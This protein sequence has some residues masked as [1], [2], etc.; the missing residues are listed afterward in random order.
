[1]HPQIIF[2]HIPKTAGTSFRKM[3]IEAN[4]PSSR[5]YHG[6]GLRS[7]FAEGRTADVVVGHTP[8]G[9]HYFTRRPVR[10]MTFLRNPIDR[11]LSFYY[12]IKDLKR[13]DLYRRHPLRNYADSVSIREF[14]ENPCFSNMQTRYIAGLL[15]NKLYPY[16]RLETFRA[17]VLEQAKRHLRGF[18]FIGLL[19]QYDRSVMMAQRVFGWEQKKSVQPQSQTDERPSVE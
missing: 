7:Y 13:T 19:E 9:L 3:V 14:Y 1:M 16:C 10:Y 2:P 11:A 15:S 18:T 8:Y 5:I 4:V 6:G 17:R 12:F